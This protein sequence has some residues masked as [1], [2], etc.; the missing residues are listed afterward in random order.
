VAATAAAKAA[1]AK[2]ELAKE[3]Q[4]DG[5]AEVGRARGFRAYA[6]AASGEGPAST[7]SIVACGT[8]GSG[9]EGGH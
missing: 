5:A 7:M 2:R 3:E 9:H 8:C 1:E 6:R 4:G